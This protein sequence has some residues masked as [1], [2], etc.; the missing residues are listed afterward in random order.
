MLLKEEIQSCTQCL[1]ASQT[2]TRIN[3]IDIIPY[4]IRIC[5]GVD[6]T[7]VEVTPGSSM[8]EGILHSQHVITSFWYNFYSF[9]SCDNGL[10][11][12]SCPHTSVAVFC[13]SLRQLRCLP[14][15]DIS[16]RGSPALT[17]C[18]I[19]SRMRRGCHD[20]RWPSLRMRLDV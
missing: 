1:Y 12:C 19:S 18:C 6:E 17:T 20:M 10:F 8:S 13:I 15:C 7:V 14:C 5:E 11:L 4:E 16:A 9:L 3:S 2:I